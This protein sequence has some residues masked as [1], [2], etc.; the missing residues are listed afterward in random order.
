MDIFID[1]MKTAIPNL[2]ESDNYKD[3]R[4]IITN[5]IRERSNDYF[6]KF[7]EEA[8]NNGFAVVQ[9]QSGQYM[10][11]DLIP[12]V[13]GKE[14]SW[15]ELDMMVRDGSYAKE[16]FEK[17]EELY[18]KFTNKLSDVYREIRKLESEMR[19]KL[20]KLDKDIVSPMLRDWIDEL[21]ETYRN[22]GLSNYL[23]EVLHNILNEIQR[24]LVSHDEDDN[25]TDDFL[26]YKVNV[27]VDNSE[28]VGPPVIIEQSP[29]Y[30]NLFGTIEKTVEPNGRVNTNFMMIKA[31]SLV[32]ANGGFIVLN[33]LDVLQEPLVWSSLKRA[34]RN[35]SVEIQSYDP[36]NMFSVSSLKPESIDIDVKVIIIGNR[37]F[38]NILFHQEPHFKKIFKVMAEFDDEMENNETNRNHYA[39]FVRKLC[40]SESLLDFDKDGVARLV[41]YGLRLS[42][43]Q[44]K[45]T[46]LFNDLADIVRESTYWA[47]LDNSDIVKEFHV[48]KAIMEKI[49][50]INLIEDKIKDSILRKDV[51]ISIDGEKVGQ[52]NGLAV[53]SV[54]E[55]SFGKPTRITATTSVGKLGVINIE[56]EAYMSGPTHDKGVMILTGYLKYKY[57]Q[58]KPLAVDASIAF[59]QSYN[60]VDGDS[61]SSTEIYAILSSL[62]GLPIRQYIAVT[63]SVNQYGEIQPIGGVNEKIEGFFEI[64]KEAGFNGKHGV[65]IPIQN[66]DNLMLR[67][68]VVDAVAEGKFHI[69]PITTIDEGIEILTGTEAGKLEDSGNYPKNTINYLV[70][71]RLR[72]FAMKYKEFNLS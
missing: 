64:C 42:E 35:R 63:G 28:L 71:E 1:T 61:A 55:L 36:L 23:K 17:L 52:V 51:L 47:K 49:G 41:E 9:V 44:D 48:E 65:I 38:Y 11:P 59:E 26:E 46:T 18:I 60:G 5:E 32:K 33:I 14:L 66:V 27:I 20:D 72:T 21:G 43:R 53:Y 39:M 40:H 7:E 10:R 31:G 56:R 58:D 34:L 29:S 30:Q 68:D 69:Y 70:N 2:F 19:D 25:P 4:N 37:F 6:K 54:G 24:F 13:N 45:L 67:K 16:E 15:Q 12:I 62:S 57:A 3:R 22:N 50:R 8:N